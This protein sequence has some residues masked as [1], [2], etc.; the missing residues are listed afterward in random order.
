MGWIVRKQYF[1]I[2]R[3]YTGQRFFQ[4]APLTKTQSP[5]LYTCQDNFF[6]MLIQ[7][8][9][10]IQQ[11]FKAKLGMIDFQ[12]LKVSLFCS[13]TFPFDIITIIVIAQYRELSVRCPDL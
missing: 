13:L 8:Y 10:F 12:L 7:F 6:A 9:M 4:V 2:I 11:K 5:V 1:E 3:V